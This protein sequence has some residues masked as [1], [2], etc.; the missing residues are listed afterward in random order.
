VLELIVRLGEIEAAVAVESVGR[1]VVVDVV[2]WGVL[3]E[4]DLRREY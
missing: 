1:A 2:V 4:L 3:A